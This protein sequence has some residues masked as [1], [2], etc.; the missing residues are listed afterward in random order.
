[1]LLPQLDAVRA[2]SDSANRY[3]DS[4]PWGMRWGL[5]QGDAVGNAARDAYLRELDGIVLPRFA[6]RIKQHLVSY[7]AEP[8]KLYVYLKAYLMLGDPKH[9]DKKHLQLL[10]DL[11]WKMPDAA[12]GAGTSL[13]KHFQSLL[14]YSDTLRPIALDRGAGRAGAQHDPPRL[15]PADHVRTAAPLLQRRYSARAAPRHHRRRAASRKCCGAERTQAVG[16][17]SELLY[18]EGVQRGHRQPAWLRSSSNSPTRH[19]CGGR[20]ACPPR[21]GPKLTSQVTELYERDYDKAWDELLNDLEIVQFSTV[22]QYS[23]E[24]SILVGPTSPLRGLLKTVVDQTSMVGASEEAG[25]RRS[26][27]APGSRKRAE[28]SVYSAQ[29]KISGTSG[30][31]AGHGDHAAFRAD[32][33]V[34]RPARPAPIDATFDQSGRFATSW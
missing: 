31:R 14:D 26:G 2:V 28:R 1:M 27:S 20:T 25:R 33:P 13:S 8:E 17:V 21:A 24:L 18:G 9:L 4:T 30:L 6:A 32:S 16:A 10:A 22:Q 29:K 19:G 7:G 11:E 23:D 3:R 5:Y 34:T 12:P 15:D